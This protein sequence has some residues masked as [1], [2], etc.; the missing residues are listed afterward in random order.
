MKLIVKY[1]KSYPLLRKNSVGKTDPL[2]THSTPDISSPL[3]SVHKRKHFKINN[4]RKILTS[5]KFNS[6]NVK[7]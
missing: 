7:K 1:L 4:P 3:F 5:N 6:R 2:K